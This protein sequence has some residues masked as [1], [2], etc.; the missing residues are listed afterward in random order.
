MFWADK[1]ADEIEKRFAAKIAAGTPLVLRDEK[2]PSGRVHVGSM[3][4]VA[5]HGLV[6]EV[7]D[8]RKIAARFLYEINDV[9]PMDDIPGYLDETVYRPY[10][11]QPLC[12]IPS[13][14]GIAKNYAEYY[15]SEFEH[16]IRGAGFQ[17][18]FYRSSDLYAR[19]DMNSTV[20]AALEKRAVIREIYQRVSGSVKPETWF[21]VTIIAQVTKAGTPTVVGWNGETL[22]WVCDATGEK[23]NVSPL[24]GNVR[25][26]WKPGWAARFA[27]L[28]VDIE[29]GGKDH[30][31]R[32]GSRDV[33]NHIA[34]EVFNVEPP[35]DIPYEFFLVGGKKMSSSKGRGASAKEIAA[36]VPAHIFRLALLGKEPKRAIDFVPNGDTIPVLFDEYDR[37]AQKAWIGIDDDDTRL[38]RHLH[39][40]GDTRH[41][42]PH[43][44]PRFSLI[45]FLVQMPH[46]DVLAETERMKGSAL[47]E[48]DREALAERGEYARLWLDQCAPEEFR[49]ELQTG[50]VPELARTFSVEQKAALQQIITVFEMNQ[51]L[52]GARLHAALHEIKATS[53]IAPKELF[54]AIYLAFLGRESGPKAGWFLSVLDRNFVLERLRTVVA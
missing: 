34:R 49:Y 20:L 18:E 11:L 26:A 31:T 1:I 12:T 45:A 53:G 21:P 8:T 38:F 10:F 40:T 2:T 19:G 32:G 6:K 42:I 14:D 25:L 23:G 30:S 29:G 28:G 43:F 9:D 50:A 47:T 36:L 17:P 22:E 39:L 4:G 41:I 33:A 16:V 44:L 51:F 27:A 48:E 24:N 15:G 46:V 13:P 35:L 54:S 52:D 3:R 7:L 5:I 37:I